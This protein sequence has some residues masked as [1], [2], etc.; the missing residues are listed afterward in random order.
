M[1]KHSPTSPSNTVA[2]S[3][4]PL[5]TYRAGRR[6]REQRT[7]QN[8]TATCWTI[9]PSSPTSA[10]SAASAATT[11]SYLTDLCSSESPTPPRSEVE[12]IRRAV[13]SLERKAL[14]ETTYL[15]NGCM[16]FCLA[17][18]LAAPGG[19]FGGLGS[20]G[21]SSDVSATVTTVTQ[22]IV[23]DVGAAL[24]TLGPDLDKT[25][26]QDELRAIIRDDFANARVVGQFE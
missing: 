1:Q 20:G 11:F 16:Y 14:V 8:R 10:S 12:S 25:V 4:V 18:K 6:S 3:V 2:V 17:V 13:R 21:G 7:R 15:A 9:S 22:P 5:N 24:T 26:A 23:D 19:M